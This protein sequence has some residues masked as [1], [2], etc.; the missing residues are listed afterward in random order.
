M[1]RHPFLMH[2]KYSE[3][4]KA[5]TLL[6]IKI[7]GDIFL[8]IYYNEYYIKGKREEGMNKMQMLLIVFGSIFFLWFAIPWGINGII[9]IGNAT[10][11]VTFGLLILYGIFQRKVHFFLAH[12]RELEGGNAVL[13]VL[14]ILVIAAVLIVAAET[15]LMVRAAGNRPP[16]N[17]TAVVL[18]CSV[19]GTRPSR[20]LKERL[21]AAYVYLMENK[22]ALCILSGGQGNGE[23][24]SEAECMYRYL[25]EKGIHQD[26]LLKEDASTNTE[27]NLLYTKQL[28]EEKGL[29][30]EITIITS[31]FHEYRANAMAEKL[32]LISYST[33]G[34][35]FF[36]YL[37][38]YYVRELY[39]ILY[40]R[41]GK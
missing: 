11:M 12:V 32:G 29:G 15:V 7:T 1:H 3:S 2:R 21:D 30:N 13:S 14:G 24:I 33:P 36:V 23:D 10:G 5:V 6:E 19:K 18:G 40:Y 25:T 27:E 35:T 17:T 8:T 39:G 16:A 31:E 26:R 34:N 37:P 9:N 41:I 4:A 20:I 28:L 38:T 22:E